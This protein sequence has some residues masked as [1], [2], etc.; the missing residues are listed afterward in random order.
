ME[1]SNVDTSN[2]WS[3]SAGCISGAA[4]FVYTNFSRILDKLDAGELLMIIITGIVGGFSGMLG[5][6]LWNLFIKPKLPRDKK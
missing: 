6:H 3:F 5:K 2:G 4:V 1:H